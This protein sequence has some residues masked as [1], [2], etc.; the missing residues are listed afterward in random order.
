MAALAVDYQE[1]IWMRMGLD[2]AHSYR[3]ATVCCSYC[4][5]CCKPVDTTTATATIAAI[6]MHFCVWACDNYESCAMARWAFG[7]QLSCVARTT[8]TWPRQACNACGQQFYHQSVSQ[9]VRGIWRH[10]RKGTEPSKPA[11]ILH[12]NA[13]N[14]HVKLQSRQSRWQ[15]AFRARS[16]H[17]SWG[18]L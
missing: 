12:K 6:G 3:Y 10:Q 14:F 8:F 15:N 17:A 13:D 16:M 1:R 4:C 7:W 9:S 2:A 18:L 5:C 11:G